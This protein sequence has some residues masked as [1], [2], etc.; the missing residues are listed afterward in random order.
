MLV[1][2]WQ[3]VNIGDIAH[4]PGLL[5]VLETYLPNAKIILWKR[6]KGEEVK[7]LLTRNFPTV[8]VIYGNVD[9]N[10]D[11]DNPEVMDA[12]KKADLM[13]HGS[14]PLL[15]GADN[16]AC[17]LKHTTKPFG[18]FGTTLQSPGEYHQTILKKASFI[19]TRETHSIDHLKKVGIEGSHIQFA[20][21]ATFYLNIRDD[22][23]AGRF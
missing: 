2:G 20:P 7:K 23:K 8:S 14:G 19:Y 22:K 1:S 18:V 10:K 12:I 6:S 21:D 13:I 4:T 5:H 17:W 16:L 11:V 9:A 3:D 15:V